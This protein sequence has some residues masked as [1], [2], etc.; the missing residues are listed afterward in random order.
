MSTWP[1]AEISNQHWFPTIIHVIQYHVIYKQFKGPQVTD[2]KSFA[3][4]PP[5]KKKNY[6]G[7]DQI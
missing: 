5:Q 4:P 6:G 2:T 1:L 7:G 3:P